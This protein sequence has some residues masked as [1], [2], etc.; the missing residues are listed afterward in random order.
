MNIRNAAVGSGLVVVAAAAAA[1]L[2]GP[3]QGISATAEELPRIVSVS[4]LG[5]IKVKPDM[6]TVSTGVTTEAR[7]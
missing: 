2:V 4:G 6:A 1:I 5:E 7:T 3:G